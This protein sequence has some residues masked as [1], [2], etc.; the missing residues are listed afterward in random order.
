LT[1]TGLTIFGCLLGLLSACRSQPVKGPEPYDLAAKP[2]D[3]EIQTLTSKSGK[4]YRYF[5]TGDAGGQQDTYKNDRDLETERLTLKNDRDFEVKRLTLLSAQLA[6]EKIDRKDMV[7]VNRRS[8]GVAKT[9]I[10]RNKPEFFRNL[11]ELLRGLPRDSQMLQLNIDRETPRVQQ[12][13]RFVATCAWIVA[14]RREE[15][16]D[17]HVIVSNG[18]KTFMN[19]VVSAIPDR[20][21]TLDREQLITVRKVFEAFVEETARPTGNYTGWGDPVPVYLEGPLL[22]DI[23]HRPGSVGPK[24]ARPKTSWA[25]RPVAHVDFESRKCR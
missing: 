5:D 20:G 3:V 9:S 23:D 18:M 22:Y 7:D 1:R 19:T 12:E 10:V 17:Y 16:G 2:A 25:I 14:D 15:D 13:M 4:T 11:A 21:N 6:D 24:E 8:R